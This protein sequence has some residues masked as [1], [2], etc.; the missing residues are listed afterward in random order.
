MVRETSDKLAGMTFPN[1]Y[2]IIIALI[3]L[4]AIFSIGSAWVNVT[5]AEN[6][7]SNVDSV[8]NGIIGLFDHFMENIDGIKEFIEW[9]NNLNNPDPGHH[10]IG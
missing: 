7:S 8:F 6:F 9:L 10:I 3:G 4:V 1:A 2:K 5:W